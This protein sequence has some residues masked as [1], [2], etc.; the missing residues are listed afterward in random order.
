MFIALWTAMVPDAAACGGFACDLA[1]SEPTP[2][3]LQAAERIV[4]GFD[5]GSGAGDGEIEMH[6]QVGFEGGA[7]DFVW[8]VPIPASPEIFLTTE[9]LFQQ[10]PLQTQPAFAL[11]VTEEGSCT[12]PREANRGSS[13]SSADMALTD[14]SPS[15]SETDAFDVEVHQTLS[16]GPYEIVELEATSV[17]DLTGWL[18]EQGY[19]LASELDAL[20][21]PYV[22]EGS[23]FVA[24]KLAADKDLGDLAPLAMRYPGEHAVIPIQLTAL[25]ATP[26]MRVEAYVFGSGRGVP[27]S[28]LHVEINEAAID[29]WSAGAN[30]SDVI[31]QAANEAGG[32]AFATD[33][34]GPTSALTP[35]FSGSFDADIL[36]ATTDPTAWTRAALASLNSTVVPPELVQVV[37]T[38]LDMP[39]GRTADEWIAC[40]LC[41]DPVIADF[42]E[43]AATDDL[44]ARVVEPLIAAQ[45]LLDDHLWMSRMTSSLDAVEMTV[46]PLFELNHDLMD[47]IFADRTAKFVYECGRSTR[48]TRAIR[49]L[50][51]SDRTLYVPSEDWL[52]DAGLSPFEFLAEH[53]ELAAQV[54]EQ[55][56][57]EGDSEVLVDHGPM[58]QT[59]A[60]NHND[61]VR[62]LGCGCNSASGPGWA[63]GLIALLGGLALRRRR[64]IVL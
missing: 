20:L 46:D 41:F 12:E 34:S 58:L 8:I 29:W 35:V 26:D 37:E 60:A 14:G 23:H 47:E 40:S 16:V 38:W 45:A 63:G 55:M 48:R 64:R 22:A 30:Y 42:D 28:Y 2:P 11:R 33:W 50:E 5:P 24:L 1:P 10:L 36:A 7:D 53:G 52:A 9:L 31:T 44:F 59:L 39:S 3:V 25:S 19:D 27:T 61:W 17:E 21:L 4:F 49:R 57:A 13:D 18:D 6:V 15:F 54:I 32:H 51:L 62:G 43:Q 56:H